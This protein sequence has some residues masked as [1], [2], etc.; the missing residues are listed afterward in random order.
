MMQELQKFTFSMCKLSGL[1]AATLAAALVA[2]CTTPKDDSA[3]ERVDEVFDVP[4]FLM[5]PAMAL[6]TNSTGFSARLEI[7]TSGKPGDKGKMGQLIGRA[8]RLVYAPDPEGGKLSKKR[9]GDRTSFIWYAAD[10]KGY[11]VNDALQGYAPISTPAKPVGV[12]FGEVST[13]T[14]EIDG[15]R[16]HR[17]DVV[18]TVD[19]GPSSEFTVWRAADLKDFP[20]QVKAKDGQFTLTFSKVRMQ[21][22][23]ADLF[24]PP[25]E[26]SKHA[27][28]A[29]MLGALLERE[30]AVKKKVP[31]EW[32]ETH[33]ENP[34]STRNP[35]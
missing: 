7:K 31:D 3:H 28:P 27:S 1:L 17:A 18:M 10:S 12:A 20:M 25:E 9:A 15:H 34:R 30:V 32:D 23:P 35:Q 11:V 6:F 2:G 22:P 26:Y 29:M 21:E 16:C 24:L 33:P 4:N 8:D 19:N 14:E 13:V 5:S